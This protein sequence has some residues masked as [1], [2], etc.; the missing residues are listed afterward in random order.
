MPPTRKVVLLPSPP[1]ALFGALSF[2][3]PA[4]GWWVVGG[5][6]VGGGAAGGCIFMRRMCIS[7][8]K[9][10]LREVTLRDKRRAREPNDERE[11]DHPG[12]INVDLKVR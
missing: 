3:A 11:W 10:R 6:G 4:E 7:G 1:T 8:R 2:P 12:L 9:Q 5:V